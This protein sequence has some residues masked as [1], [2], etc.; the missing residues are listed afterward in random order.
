MSKTLIIAEAG[1]NHNGSLKLAKK[2]ISSAKKMGADV[3]KF[4]IF[5][6]D[7]LA[8]KSTPKAEYQKK[9][10]FKNQHEMLKK[11]ELNDDDFIELSRFSKKKK[12]EF[13]ASFFHEKDLNIVPKLGI[14]RIKIPSGE[15]TNYSLLKKVGSIK[16][17]IILSTGMSNLKEINQAINLLIKSGAKKKN[18]TILH[19]NTEYPSPLK[20]VNL[21]AINIL[22]KTFKTQ[23]GYSDHTIS[24]ETPIAAVAVGAEI[25]EKH[26]TLSKNLQGPDHKSSL[27]STEFKKMTLSIRN[28]EKLLG[29][30]DKFIS[31]SEKKNILKCR[32]YLVAKK[33]IKKNETF[34]FH[35][36]SLKRTGSG[37][38]SPMEIPK[39][40]K[41]KAKK[42]YKKN[43]KI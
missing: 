20:D 10:K 3:I 1:V 39:L 35:N 28:T 12:I 36:T 43:E 21:R 30:E 4:Q 37:G 5:K 25:I 24:N 41:K 11:L 29:Y 9:T 33:D 16:K 6:A 22:R 38:I 15:I 8:S 31:Q 23:V 14:K 2:L 34:G 7:R 42:N 26:F 18:I 13:S 32:Q 19:C 27:T 17:K 40:F